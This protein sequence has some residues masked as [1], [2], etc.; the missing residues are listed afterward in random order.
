[1]LRKFSSW[2]FGLTVLLASAPV[3]AEEEPVPGLSGGDIGPTLLQL[4]GALLLIIIIIYLSVWLMKK[5]SGGKIAGGGNLISI[6][7]RRHLAP[8]Q[9]LYLIK[10]GEKHL[11]IGASDS[12]L[13]KLSDIDGLEIKMEKPS[14]A[15]G[16]SRF[17]QALKQAKESLMPRLIVKEK[18]VEA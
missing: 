16:V 2:L 10:V 14:P 15:Y 12:G 7:E 13:Q 18:S 4:A 5:Y 6:V 17:S 9:A 11:L 8:K 3:W 1:M